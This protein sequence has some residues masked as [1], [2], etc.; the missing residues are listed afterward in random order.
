MALCSLSTGRMDTPYSFASGIMI[1]PAVTR[2]SL[3]ASAMVFFAFIAAIV[4]RIP[5]IPTIAVTTMSHGS[6]VAHLIKPSML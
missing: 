3:F 2:V 1:C 6:M 4:G 5:S